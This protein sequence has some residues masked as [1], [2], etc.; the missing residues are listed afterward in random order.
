MNFVM[1]GIVVWVMDVVE[2]LIQQCGYGGFFF[3]DVVQVVGICKFS[4]YYYF[5]IKVEFVVVLVWCYIECFEFVLV[6]I[7]VVWCDLLV[8]FR[9]YVQLFVIIYV[10]DGCL[11]VC[12]MFGVEVDVLLVDVVDVVVGFFQF[13]FI[14]F[15]VVFCDVQ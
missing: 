5:C 1:V 11:C 8:W 12:G 6:V 15:I 4:V 2:V 13:N 14:W 10:Q 9:V 3:D 7:D